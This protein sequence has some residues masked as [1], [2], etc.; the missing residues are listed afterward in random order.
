[1]LGLLAM[2]KA[3]W[4]VIGSA[5]LVLAVGGSFVACGGDDGIAAGNGDGGV[6]GNVSGDATS[7]DGQSGDGASGDGGGGG[8][9]GLCVPKACL[10]TYQCGDLDDGCGHVLTCGK[11]CTG[12]KICDSTTH[13]CVTAGNACQAQGATCGTIKDACGVALDCGACPTGQVCNGQTHT[14]VPA[15]SSDA[16]GGCNPGKLTCTGPNGQVLCGTI[17]DGCGNFKNCS[18]PNGQQCGA[19]GPG[20]CGVAPECTPPADGGTTCGTFPNACGSGNVSCGTCAAGQT[21]NSNHQCVTCVPIPSPCGAAVCG[22]AS[23]GCGN[24]V[25]CGSCSGNDVCNKGACCTPLT[26][27]GLA[28]GGLPDG[29]ALGCNAV[30]DSCG[31]FLV[32]EKCTAT[33]RCVTDSCTDCPDCDG[34]VCDKTANCCFPKTCSDFPNAGCGAVN[35]GCDIY[36]V[37][38]PC[39][40]GQYCM[41]DGTCCMPQGCAG[42]T[43]IVDDGCGHQINCN[44]G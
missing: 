36:K 40:S 19:G 9:S 24:S 8:D 7:G 17:G 26:C 37:C 42:R 30:S 14:C 20:V 18:C 13:T 1:L 33:Q 25:K 15:S 21:C 23:D 22:S 2:S 31:G 34:G 4:F 16:G 39:S 6:D 38:N 29:G 27:A 11:A 3:P 5:C 44:P 43:G 32:C 10:A 28:D 35:L 41:G 12:G